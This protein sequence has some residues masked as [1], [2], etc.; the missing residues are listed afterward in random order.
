MDQDL[1]AHMTSSWEKSIYRKIDPL[2][3]AS[4]LFEVIRFV[5]SI[6]VSCRVK[7]V[8]L[9]F[10]FFIETVAKGLVV[11]LPGKE[12]IAKKIFG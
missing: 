4:L 9:K 8:I 1:D 2:S 6:T 10:E 5:F 7:H 11:R 12:I 3:S